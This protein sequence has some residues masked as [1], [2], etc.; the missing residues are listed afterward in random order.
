MARYNKVLIG[1]VGYNCPQTREAQMTAATAPGSLVF[2][3]SG[4]L[5]VHATDGGGSDTKLYLLDA[6]FAGGGQIDDNVAQDDTGAAY[7][8]EDDVIY[9]ALVA[10]ANNIDVIGKPLTSNG[11][12][13]LRVGVV[14]VDDILFYSDEIYNNTSGSAQIVK[15]RK[16]N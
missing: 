6:D 5:A 2:L 12:G 14:G 11:D 15:V 4:K 9:G 16:A 7:H 1:P 3:S 8:L 13:T 10:T